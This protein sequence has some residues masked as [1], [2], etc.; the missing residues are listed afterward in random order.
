A[1]LWLHSGRWYVYGDEMFRLKDRHGRDFCL[2]PTHE[3]MITTIVKN[4]IRSYRQLPINLYQIQNKY[5]DERR[6]RFGLMRGREFIMKDAYSF[7]R[8]LAGLQISYSL[9]FRTYE[10]IFSRCGLVF[11]AVEADSGAIGGSGSHEFMAITDAGEAEIVFCRQCSYAANVE[12]ARAAANEIE[13]GQPTVKTAGNWEKIETKEQKTIEQV[14]NFLSV[15]R[16]SVIKAVAYFADQQPVVG[17]I[18]GD[19]EI[20]ETK[21]KNILGCLELRLADPDDFAIWVGEA[22]G[23]LGPIGLA[24]GVRAVADHSVMNMPTAVCGANQRDYHLINVVPGRDLTGLKIADLRLVREGDQCPN[25][26]GVLQAARGVEVGQVFQLGDKYSAAL[27]AVYLDEQGV[28]R[29]MVMGCYGIGVSRT[30]QAV[31]EQHNDADGIVWPLAIAPFHAYVT[32]VNINDGQQ[33]DMAGQ[34]YDQLRRRGAE[35]GIDESDER[36]GAK[37]KEADLIGV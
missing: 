27:K 6:P 14:C 7:D 5:R 20:N 26:R 11:R 16:Q 8:D 32:P 31:V 18:R 37:F 3:E 9:M 35:T 4:D 34:V 30:L 1:E 36:G 28:E 13:P 12:K 33:R 25:C 21:L 17:F 29:P 22:C 2:A 24:E 10:R 23:Y 15:D 19:L